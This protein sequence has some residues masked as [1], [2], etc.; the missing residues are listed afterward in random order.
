MNACHLRK[1]ASFALLTAS[2]VGCSGSKAKGETT[3]D[4]VSPLSLELPRDTTATR[5]DVERI[6][7]GS[8]ALGGC[9]AG[10]PAAADLSLALAGGS[11][12]A[13]VVGRPSRE[14]P[15]LLLVLAGDPERSWM[16]QKLTGNSCNFAAQCTS[17]L[18]CGE[19]MPFGEA[20]PA[21]DVTVVAAWIEAGAQR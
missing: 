16:V 8:C 15:S 19:R 4:G 5:G 7:A 11:W 17:E 10:T 12:V 14:N 13:N 1:L 2:V 21:S 18:G 20:L 6:L 3:C 9:H